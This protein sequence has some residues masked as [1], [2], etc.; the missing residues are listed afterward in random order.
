MSV[1]GDERT[2]VDIRPFSGGADIEKHVAAGDAAIFD[3]PP[4][5][6]CPPASIQWLDASGGVLV[7]TAAG[8]HHITLSNQ[9]V[10]LNTDYDVHNNAVYRATATNGYTQ[11]TT[12]SRLYVLRVQRE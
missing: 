10:L 12:S 5:D 3:L 11:R 6:S 4:V 9:L 7:N 1:N 8:G 2:F